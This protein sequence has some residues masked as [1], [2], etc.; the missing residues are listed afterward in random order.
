MI[1]VRS[2]L[3]SVCVW[4]LTLG[5]A[6]AV[7][8]DDL[9]EVGVVVPD[10]TP[11]ARMDALPLA[12]QQV[13]GRVSGKVI[14]PGFSADEISRVY[15]EGFGYQSLDDGEQGL[16]LNARF[17]RTQIN[18]WLASQQLPVWGDHRPQVLV[19][20]GVVT[21]SGRIALDEV[22]AAE[23]HAD[24][25]FEFYGLPVVFPVGDLEDSLALPVGRLFGMFR[26]DIKAASERYGTPAVVAARVMPFADYWRVDGY[27]TYGNDSV[28]ISERAETPEQGADV[29]AAAVAAYFS[30]RFG[31]V[32]NLDAV[33][34]DAQT[35]SVA[36]VADYGDYQQLL[37]LVGSVSG[38]SDVTVTAVQDD[39]L[40][41]AVSLKADWQQV[42]ANIVLDR[43]IRKDADTGELIWNP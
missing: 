9:Y 37:R 13:I 41:L 33:P 31:V 1:L 30:G 43:R 34:G 10:R 19:W 2:V 4:L 21:D 35:M 7:V 36:G 12:M 23:H 28:S 5:S 42:L 15:L 8:V 26:S 27:L 3:L 14:D 6:Q 20:L 38:V 24:D 25:A 32:A 22:S 17:R 39:V 18:E 11:A 40:T 16:E 29:L